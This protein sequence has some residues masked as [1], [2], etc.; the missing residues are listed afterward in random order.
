[1]TISA[2]KIQGEI[3]DFEKSTD[4]KKIQE[5]GYYFLQLMDD[6]HISILIQND[7][8]KAMRENNKNRMVFLAKQV[9]QTIEKR[10]KSKSVPRRGKRTW[11]KKI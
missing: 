7:F 2:R 1:M 3:E 6:Y 5:F 8:H 10:S 4:D 9:L 11:D